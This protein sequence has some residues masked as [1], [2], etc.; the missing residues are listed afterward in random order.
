MHISIKI[1]KIVEITILVFPILWY[2]CNSKR[3]EYK[4]LSKL[5]QYTLCDLKS[6]LFSAVTVHILRAAN[7]VAAYVVYDHFLRC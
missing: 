5:S 4:G 1:L 2:M 7:E 6:I 3:T